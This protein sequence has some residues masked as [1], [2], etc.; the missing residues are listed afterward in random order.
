[1]VLKAAVIKL[2]AY[3]PK[4]G[5]RINTGRDIQKVR[6]RREKGIA[7]RL[8]KCM[9]AFLS[10][11]LISV[12]IISFSAN[13]AVSWPYPGGDIKAESAVV[14]DADTKTVLWGRNQDEQHYPA[15]ITKMMTALVVVENCSMDERVPITANAVYGLE[16]GATTAGLS[17]DDIL[18]VE[19]LLYALLLRSANDAANA[20]AI[21][22]AGSISDFADL[23]NKRAGELG[24]KNTDFKNPSGLTD[25]E[26]LTTAYDMALIA[27]EF[28]NNDTLLEIES[29]DSYKLPATKKNPSGLTVTMGHKM[30]RSG[31]AYSD[32]RVIAGKTG[33]TTASG[34]TLVTAAAENGRRIIVVCMKDK[35]PYHYTDTGTLMSFGFNSFENATVSDPVKMFDCARRLV[36]DKICSAGSID[37]KTDEELTVTLPRGADTAE[38]TAEYEYNLG[39]AAPD[40]AK[41]RLKAYYDDR[42]VGSVWLI[43]DAVSS[44]EFVELS[45][46]SGTTKALSITVIIIIAAAIA[47]LIA[48][49]LGIHA[50]KKE[51]ERR[52]RF[53]QRQRRRLKAM[54]LS[55]DELDTEV[56]RRRRERLETGEASKISKPAESAK[57]LDS[58]NKAEGTEKSEAGRR[59]ERR[60]RRAEARRRNEEFKGI[61]EQGF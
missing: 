38:L 44:L 42:C 43:N 14:M 49:G 7:C 58:I 3:Q 40:M 2:N 9:T 33:F 1:M 32:E 50:R 16:A 34:N 24:C 37:I 11:A 28:I 56:R 12:N 61:D 30:L 13:A 19:D 41:A 45:E 10:V 26:H 22:V 51:E 23:M 53:R 29:H 15:S 25:S 46:M 27:A 60:L 57:K 36:A 55:K 52:K 20:L 54:G 5:R 31:T 39:D 47:A 6:P 48:A 17:V 21:H 4:C 8:G 18:S 35:T 59:T